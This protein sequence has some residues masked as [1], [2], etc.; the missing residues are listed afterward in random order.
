MPR[1]CLRRRLTSIEDPSPN[2][3]A[4]GRDPQHAVIAVTTGLLSMTNRYELEGVV[5]HEMSHIQNY[6]IRVQT[7]A[8]VLAG[9]VVLMSDWMIRSLFWG[10]RG[11]SRDRGG[12]NPVMLVILVLGLILA[13][14]GPVLAQL[15]RLAISRR[16]EYLADAS[17]VRL[18]RYPDGLAS[19][20]A[21][22]AAYSQ[23]VRNAN[24]ATAGLYIVN[25]LKGSNV[26]K[27]FSTHPPIEDRIAR[28]RA[29]DVGV[30][31][32]EPA[33]PAAS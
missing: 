19:A 11:R 3:F 12:N 9:M 31:Q 10:R 29:M 24:K 13:I 23:P 18:T 28:L 32:G 33:A 8:V 20:L 27:L 30:P 5:A 21:K 2:A 14:F 16:R 1:G 7:I 17:G 22:L 15:M 26:S 25:P 6:D 4:T